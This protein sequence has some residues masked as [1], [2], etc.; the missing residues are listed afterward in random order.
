MKLQG[1]YIYKMS[2]NFSQKKSEVKNFLWTPFNLKKV[3]LLYKAAEKK[4]AD[5]DSSTVPAQMNTNI[6]KSLL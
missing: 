5:P 3:W 2:H 1:N 4:K 6:P